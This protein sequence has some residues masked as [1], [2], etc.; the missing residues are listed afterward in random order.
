MTIH[1]GPSS[2][3]MDDHEFRSVTFQRV[4]QYLRRHISNINL[5]RFQYQSNPE[6]TPVE[7]LKLFLQYVTLFQ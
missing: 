4:Y 2:I 6:G 1:V 7:C 5:D 3:G